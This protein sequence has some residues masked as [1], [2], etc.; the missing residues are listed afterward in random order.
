MMDLGNLAERL[1]DLSYDYDPY[2]FHDNYTDKEEALCEVLKSLET[3]DVDTFVLFCD[4][5]A[6]EY[7]EDPDEYDRD[8]YEEAVLVKENLE[9]LFLEYN[10]ENIERE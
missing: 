9:E 6:E 8:L 7:V 10:A 2:E 5:I 3:G 4:E 1:V